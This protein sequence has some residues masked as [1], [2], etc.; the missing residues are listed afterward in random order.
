[1]YTR[2]E[3]DGYRSLMI[4][5]R[6]DLSNPNIVHVCGFSEEELSLPKTFAGAKVKGMSAISGCQSTVSAHCK[7]FKAS[8]PWLPMPTEYGTALHGLTAGAGLT[9]RSTGNTSN[10][11]CPTQHYRA[12]CTH[13]MNDLHSITIQD[14]G[15]CTLVILADCIEVGFPRGATP[16]QRLFRLLYSLYGRQTYL[17]LPSLVVMGHTLP[18]PKPLL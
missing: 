7:T 14:R 18:R 2:G 3:G 1:M 15:C 16:K 12:C 4:V 9:F 8:V 6:I 11:N 10:T 17:S 5:L 13:W